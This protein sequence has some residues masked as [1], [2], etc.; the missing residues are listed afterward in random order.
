MGEGRSRSGQAAVVIIGAR[1]AQAS[2]PRLCAHL[3]ITAQTPTLP[4]AATH[5]DRPGGPHVD[6]RDSAGRYGHRLLL[7]FGQGP[8]TG[9]WG[10]SSTVRRY[11]RV[12][13]R[14]LMPCKPRS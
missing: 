4:A 6:T 2:C 1:H 14:R 9:G 11:A 7:F 5:I 13:A 10:W 12:G 3:V 8:A